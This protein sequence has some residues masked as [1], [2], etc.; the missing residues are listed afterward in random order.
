LGVVYDPIRDEC[1]TAARG[2]G[3][4]LNGL[5]L[6]NGSAAMPLNRCLAIVDFKRLTP[7]LADRLS[8]A[9]PYCSHRYLGAGALE[10]CWL[11]AG[12]FQLYLHAHQRLWDFA[13][14]ALALQEAGGFASTLEGESLFPA[15]T[16]ARSVV[17]AANRPLFENW[18]GALG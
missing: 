6:K 4:W 17:A 10:W 3:A 18:L 1:F 5:P 16:E 9:P 13:A 8:H 7:A 11:A 2:C 12:R 15:V 14:G